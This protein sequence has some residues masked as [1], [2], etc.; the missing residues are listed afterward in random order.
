MLSR[1]L[2]LAP[3]V[4]ALIA[5]AFAQSV[6]ENVDGEQK[7]DGSEP[8]SISSKGMIILCTIVALVI[9]IGISFTTIFIVFKKRRW[10]TRE[11]L[12]STDRVTP[13]LERA[14]TVKTPTSQLQ[15]V[16]IPTS[17]E[18]FSGSRTQHDLERSGE[19]EK[20]DTSELTAAP[21][22]WGSFFSF[23]GTRGRQ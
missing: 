5:Q 22:G 8:K 3:V 2:Y 1:R 19:F 23:G 10:Q 18:A 13:D 17:P 12:S 14:S 7:N 21:R 11:A 4:A 20:P 9:I 6:L 15:R 16:D